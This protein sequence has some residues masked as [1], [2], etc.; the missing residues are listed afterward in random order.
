MI[1]VRLCVDLVGCEGLVIGLCCLVYFFYF[2]VEGNCFLGGLFLGLGG[3][4]WFFFDRYFRFGVLVGGV[5]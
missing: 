2:C 4:F 1:G 5:F 3:G